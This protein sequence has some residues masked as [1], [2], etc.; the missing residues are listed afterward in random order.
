MHVTGGGYS[1]AR[2]TFAN[3]GVDASGRN[4]YIFNSTGRELSVRP[5]HNATGKGRR[6]AENHCRPDSPFPSATIQFGVVYDHRRP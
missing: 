5:S 2:T 3:L 6:K 4:P 1:L